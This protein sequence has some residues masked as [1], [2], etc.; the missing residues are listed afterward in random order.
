MTEYGRNRT[1]HIHLTIWT[2]ETGDILNSKFLA[3]EL[4]SHAFE[5]TIFRSNNQG[6]S[7]RT[8]E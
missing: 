7:R 4:S 5:S 3:G 6:L 2:D 1:Y 8:V